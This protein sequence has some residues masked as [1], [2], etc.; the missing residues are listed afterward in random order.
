M[1]A[2]AACARCVFRKD[3]VS[4]TPEVPPSEISRWRA[5]ARVLRSPL[6]AVG[7]TLFPSCCSLCGSPLPQISSAP[8]CAAC[9]AEVSLSRDSAP[10]T[11][12]ARC[13]DSLDGSSFT[14]GSGSNTSCLCRAC[15][16]APPSFVK[17]I[18]CGPY[19]GRMRELIHA[20]KYDRLHAVAPRLGAL[21]A[22]AIAQIAT[23]GPA[24]L[25][26]VP[27]PLHRAKY[28]ERGFN[29]ARLIAVEAIACA[30]RKN[31]RCRL[32][33]ASGTLVR[34]RA[35]D[36]QA[37]LT[38][39]QRRLNLRGAFGVSNPAAVAGK[40]ILLIDDI[41]TTGATARAASRVLMEAGAQ[42]VW[43]ATL[44]RARRNEPFFN[45][46]ALIARTAAEDSLPT[47]LAHDV[48]HE[49]A[50]MNADHQ[51]SF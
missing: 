41:L 49:R 2:T 33:L 19:E 16:L 42:A 30:R 14:S 38:P 18:S 40:S 36:S 25:L 4:L 43:V 15:R 12:C 37:G 51:P 26:V 22:D 10:E 5:I 3:S 46:A 45:R 24:E 17:A 1:I 39:R 50:T 7:C 11:E 8:I 34:L 32:V 35:T 6:D 29:Q 13:G 48:R 27:V 31:P 28:A 9:W 23:D 21:L 20:L 44:A 47:N